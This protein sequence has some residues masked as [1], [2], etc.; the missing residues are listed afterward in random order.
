[1]SLRLGQNLG[2]PGI[3]F[4]SVTCLEVYNLLCTENEDLD[5]WFMPM[6]TADFTAQT[7][8]IYEVLTGV[9]FPND[10]IT[11]VQMVGPARADIFARKCQDYRRWIT[12]LTEDGLGRVEPWIQ[13]DN[14]AV[15]LLQN[16]CLPEDWQLGDQQL[17]ERMLDWV[18]ANPHRTP[19]QRRP[20][21][22]WKQVPKVPAQDQLVPPQAAQAA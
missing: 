15:L 12:R 13:E 1:M 22:Q 20:W 18:P 4:L 14:R 5:I 9:G 21:W 16:H 7:R 6:P 17:L 8:S 10:D 19:P 2:N 11:V 3:E